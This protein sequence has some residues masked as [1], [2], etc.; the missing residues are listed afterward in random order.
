MFHD[1]G[2]IV[3]YLRGELPFPLSLNVFRTQGRPIWVYYPMIY[4]R[5]DYVSVLLTNYGTFETALGKEDQDPFGLIDLPE[6]GYGF[7]LPHF[8]TKVELLNELIKLEKQER[9]RFHLMYQKPLRRW[10]IRSQLN[11]PQLEFPRVI[12]NT[13]MEFL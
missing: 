6:L 9:L 3:D 8:E 7:D 12:Q 2:E 10:F 1:N 4:C 13:M 5:F 11:R